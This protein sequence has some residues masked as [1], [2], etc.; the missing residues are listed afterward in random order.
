MKIT[1]TQLKRAGACR[2][3]VE[4]FRTTFGTSVTVTRALCLA[5]AEKFDWDWGAAHLLRPSMRA[6]YDR[7]RAPAQAKYERVRAAAGAEYDR[8]RAE[9]FGVLAE[10]QPE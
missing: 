6:E 9:C 3:Q 1:I 10:D 4:L 8:L 5:H 7:L 2:D